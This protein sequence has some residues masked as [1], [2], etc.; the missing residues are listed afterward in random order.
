MKKY[1]KLKKGE[2][3]YFEAVDHHGQL[4]KPDKKPAILP[5]FGVYLGDEIQNGIRM[6][7]FLHTGVPDDQD[8][9]SQSA[10]IKSAIIK[11]KRLR[12]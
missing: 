3:Y 7:L 10:I 2:P 8:T 6:A 5:G 1:L 9:W 11:A 12:V 4:G